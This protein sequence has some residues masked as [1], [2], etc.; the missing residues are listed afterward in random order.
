[1]PGRRSL[2]ARA[3]PPWCTE[4]CAS[5]RT[6]VFGVLIRQSK[7]RTFDA[8]TEGVLLDNQDLRPPGEL[9]RHRDDRH[10]RARVQRHELGA[11]AN[12]GLLQSLPVGRLQ[13]GLTGL[14]AT[15]HTLPVARIFPPEQPVDEPIA[16]TAERE[17][18]NL[19]RRTSGAN[20]SHLPTEGLRR[21]GFGGSSGKRSCRRQR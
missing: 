18:Q 13:R 6:A 20:L 10:R 15:G 11:I 19:G 14:S 7:L 3:A 17:D 1:M 21:L 8:D 12:T 2:T 16:L 4:T 5:D 9:T